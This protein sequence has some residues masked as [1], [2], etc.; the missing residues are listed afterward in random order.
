MN[1]FLLYLLLLKATLTSF[2]GM[3][4]LPIIREDL[5]VR[6]RVLTDRQ[7]NTAVAAGRSGPGPIGVYVV[8]VGY[9]VAGPSGG[10][11][12][13]LAMI[14]PAF[15]I[16]PLLRYLGSHAERSEVKRAT[17]AAMLAGAGLIIAAT[18]PLAR[19]AVLG[20]LT[21]AIALSAGIVLVVTRV[22]SL[23]VIAVSAVAGLL[24]GIAGWS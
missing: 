23:W 6:H 14:T 7:L 16:I 10:I 12:G 9:L 3:G 1:L 19:D 8:N 15:L 20:P 4:S 13:W 21:L 5:V 2:S 24:G 11:A 22:E 17:E 18:V